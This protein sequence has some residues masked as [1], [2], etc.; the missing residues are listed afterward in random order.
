VLDRTPFYAEMGGQ[1]ADTGVVTTDSGRFEVRDVRRDSGGRYLHSGVCAEG[2]I[3]VGADAKAAVNV[4]RRRAIMRAHSATHLLQSALRGVLGTHVRQAG[5]LVEPDRLRFDFTHVAA[6]TRDELQRVEEIVNGAILDALEVDV[7]EMSLDDARE[8]GATALFDEKYGEVVRVV[9]MGGFSVEL[10]GGTHLDNTAKAGFFQITGEFSVAS[11]VRRIEAVTGR[12]AHRAASGARERL[13]K[14]AATLRLNSPSELE[15]RAGQILGE[16]R[17]LRREVES[18]AAKDA[19]GEAARFLAGARDV[20]GIKTITAAL[21]RASADRLRQVGDYLKSNDDNVAAVL[22]SS[23]G[24]KLTF[25]AVCGKN[26]ISRGI[27]AGDLVKA[28][29]AVCGGSGGG[30]PDSAMGGG[31]DIN[32][33]DDALAITD[34]YIYSI[35]TASP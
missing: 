15:Q 5:S 2:E 32:K 6:L 34:N 23:E 21:G 7:R 28:V 13:E 31:K 17:E 14:L 18:Y 35:V 8:K 11:G 12:Q 16:L 19:G 4:E 3:R 30:K 33:L 24:D 26:A 25:L 20:G 9:S 10:C 29:T 1:S 27:K 22:A